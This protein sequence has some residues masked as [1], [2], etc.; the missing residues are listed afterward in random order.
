MEHAESENSPKPTPGAESQVEGK[1]PPPD[2]K[3][4]AAAGSDQTHQV[5]RGSMKAEVEGLKT[6][7]AGRAIRENLLATLLLIIIALL[8]AK[9][10][11][12]AEKFNE[13]RAQREARLQLIEQKQEILRIFADAIPRNLSIANEYRALQLEIDR[14]ATAPE[15]DDRSIPADTA[16]MRE[17]VK[18]WRA[19]THYMTAC[20]LV[21]ARFPSSAS[22]AAGVRQ[23]IDLLTEL[24]LS[25][26]AE[27][28][29]LLNA[30]L[31]R[32]P[33]SALGPG[34]P[35]PPVQQAQAAIDEWLEGFQT[36]YS[37]ADGW[38]EIVKARESD[39]SDPEL[40]RARS[41][42][43]LAL[44]LAIVRAVD[45][46]YIETISEMG[47][48]IQAENKELGLENNE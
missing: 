46:L 38:N 1:P 39:P 13:Q 6:F 9:L 2:A 34:P 25:N 33:G 11:G 18:E 31:T 36:E 19:G 30:I 44:R 29:A 28:Q 7:W 47:K 4:A 24:R 15:V 3:H 27:S 17:L 45:I 23:C 41:N 21:E 37:H 5:S 43:S 22:Y 14:Q 10:F 8:S 42:A 40:I 32:I 20:Q 12:M 48:D 26:T 35:F 16:H